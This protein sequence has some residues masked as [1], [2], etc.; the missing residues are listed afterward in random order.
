MY[1]RDLPPIV[2]Q[3]I[4]QG[5]EAVLR[6]DYSSAIAEWEVAK[7]N[8]ISR[9]KSAKADSTTEVSIDRHLALGYQKIGNL[10]EAET[11]IASAM[12]LIE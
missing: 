5:R 11:A 6:N 3:Q 7:K 10:A 8:N 4:E 12:E 9:R 2:R 1:L